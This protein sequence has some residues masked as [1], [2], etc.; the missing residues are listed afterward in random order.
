MRWVICFLVGLAT[1]VFARPATV[2]TSDG[3]RYEGETFI[4]PT[5]MVNIIPIGRNMARIKLTTVRQLTFNTTNTTGTATSTNAPRQ[6]VLLRR[7][8]VL[9]GAITAADDTA[10]KLATGPRTLSVPTASVSALLFQPLTPELIA[11]FPP[12]RKGALLT[13]G[14]FYDGDFR[15][16]E[17]QRV[18]ISS[19][20]F[21]PRTFDA[22]SQVVAVVLRPLAAVPATYELRLLNGSI[23]FTDVIRAEPD[24]L[25]IEDVSLGAIQFPLNDLHQL[26]RKRR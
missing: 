4:D 12:G 18:Q 7:G 24:R 20:L 16:V 2:I 8:A 26:I 22:G 21:G 25:F 9:A 13:S 11:K 14:D 10:V 5:G 3:F 6:Q 23:F 17:N 1:T 15:S 19:V